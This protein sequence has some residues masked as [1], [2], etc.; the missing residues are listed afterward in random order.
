MNELDKRKTNGGH[1]TKSLDPNDRRRN[2]F[3]GVLAEVM[4]KDELGDVFKMLHNEAIA[5]QDIQAAKLLIEYA[6]GKPH[7]S[8]E[9]T[10]EGTFSISMS[11]LVSFNTIDVTPEEDE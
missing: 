6:V 3:K 4:T 5:N 1:S 7:Q 8:V 10:E 11:D 2:Q 9:V